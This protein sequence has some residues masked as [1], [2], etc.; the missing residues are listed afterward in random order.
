VSITDWL[1]VA[2]AR[3]D[4]VVRVDFFLA[5]RPGIEKFW[6]VLG[7]LIAV[8]GQQEMDDFSSP[9]DAEAFVS[10][11]GAPLDHFTDHLI[12]RRWHHEP[13]ALSQGVPDLIGK[14]PAEPTDEF[15][16]KSRF[17]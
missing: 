8:D 14:I 11:I 6:A 15:P 5:R 12:E 16:L 10:A 9:Y 1:N 2:V 13:V 7:L 4:L 17:A 3:A